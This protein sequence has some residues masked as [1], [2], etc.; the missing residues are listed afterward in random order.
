MRIGIGLVAATTVATLATAGCTFSFDGPV[1]TASD[2]AGELVAEPRALA[3][4]TGV[5]VTGSADLV[6]TEGATFSVTVTAD[7]AL[8]EHIETTVT[9]GV[10]DISQHY[11]IIGAQPDVTIN[12]VVPALSDVRLTGSSDATIAASHAEAL[13]V[14]VTG[15]SDV[16]LTSAVPSLSIVVSGSGDIVA[17]G[18][19]SDVSIEI[20]GAGDVD[21]K[22]LESTDATVE[23]SG[24][25]S[26]V[27]AVSDSLDAR[28]SGAGEVIYSG[29]PTLTTSITGAGG[30]HAAAE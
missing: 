20:T 28:I 18:E 2:L 26:V 22:E 19:A 17:R 21:A 5:E 4:F 12:V 16:D 1:M 7:E 11:T 30:V 6:V 14:E 29:N 10:L 25:G 27:L 23:I 8:L 13:N 15:S 9:D 3:D 24:A